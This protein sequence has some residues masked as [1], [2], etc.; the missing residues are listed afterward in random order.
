MTFT[1][2]SPYIVHL[3]DWANTKT[4]IM[5]YFNNNNNCIF[6][7]KVYIL[8]MFVFVTLII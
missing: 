6:G 8:Y 2:T 7:H 4:K 1:I 3:I 5:D